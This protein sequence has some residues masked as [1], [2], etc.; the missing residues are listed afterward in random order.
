M[1]QWLG[2]CT[3]TAVGLGSIPGWGTKIQQAAMHSQKKKK[4]PW[5]PSTLESKL[6][7]PTMAYDSTSPLIHHFSPLLPM[8]FALSKVQHQR[9]DSKSDSLQVIPRS[10]AYQCYDLGG[11]TYPSLCLCCFI[12]K[13]G[14]PHRV[15][16]RNE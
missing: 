7:L 15:M 2:L 8:P 1:V 11:I 3:F 12:Y 4:L 16:V 10:A 6:K 13:F 14:P 5:L 9:P